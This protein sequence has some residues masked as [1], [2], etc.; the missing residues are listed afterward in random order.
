LEDDDFLI[1]AAV[2]ATVLSQK[3]HGDFVVRQRMN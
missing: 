1:I 2:A 3:V